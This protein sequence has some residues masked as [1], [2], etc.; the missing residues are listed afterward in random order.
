[1]RNL[2]TITSEVT[3]LDI[4]ANGFWGGRFERT[5]QDIRVFNPR[6]PTNKYT[7]LSRNMRVKR[8]EHTNRG[9]EKLSMALSHHWYI[10]FRRGGG[11]GRGG[12][13]N[14]SVFF[15]KILAS[16]LKRNGTLHTAKLRWL[17]CCFSLSI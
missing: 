3:W 15:Y 13:T 4:T 5:Y 10:C 12:W 9:H 6:A 11:G 2:S 16:L 7:V 1:M 14:K 8:K 17:R